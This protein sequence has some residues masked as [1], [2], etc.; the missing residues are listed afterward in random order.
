MRKLL[1]LC[2]VILS[3]Q[4]TA[5]ET[6]Y[7]K[8]V[9]ILNE[10]WFGHDNSSIS[11]FDEANE[12]YYGVFKKEN[13]PQNGQQ[14]K[15]L[16]CTAQHGIIYGNKMII[17]AKQDKEASSMADGGRVT[18]AEYPSL[19]CIKQ[20]AMLEKNPL[21]GKSMADGRAC[22]G[23]NDSTVYLGSSNGIFV[24]NL[25]TLEIEKK[26]E[27]TDN[28]LITGDE[29]NANGTGPLYRNQIGIMIRGTDYVFA[30]YQDKGVLVIDPVT[31]SIIRT[32]P[33]CYS[34]MVMDVKGNI[35][36]G[37]NIN[38]N[39]NYLEYPYGKSGEE[40]WGF[41]LLKINQHTL[42]TSAIRLSNDKSKMVTQSWYAWTPGVLQADSRY[43][44]LYW[45]DPL[46]W[47]HGQQCKK[48]YKLDIATQQLSQHFDATTVQGGSSNTLYTGTGFGVNPLNNQIYAFIQSGAIYE[49]NFLLSRL[50]SNG[51]EIITKRLVS[52]WWYPSMLI[53]ADRYAPELKGE[54]P[55]TI[56]INPDNPL[57][58]LY[59]GDK[60]TDKDNLDAAIVKSAVVSNP[61]IV[62]AWVKADTLYAEANTGEP[63]VASLSLKFNSNGKTISHGINVE[64]V[65]PAIVSGVSLVQSQI[66]LVKGDSVQLNATIEPANALN[67]AV[68]WTTDNT[69][70]ATVTTNGWVKG[71]SNGKTTVTVTTAQ[72][73]YTST[74]E[75]TVIEPIQQVIISHYTKELEINKPFTIIATPMPLEADNRALT[76]SSSN[77]DV[78]KVEPVT[79]APGNKFE[80]AIV[81]A[82]KPGEAK[83]YAASSFMPQV[84]DSCIVLIGQPVVPV[85]SIDIAGNATLYTGK[86]HQL[87]A[88][89]LPS[90]ATNPAIRWSSNNTNIA[91]VS[92]NGLVQGI[93]SGKAI[94]SATAK[95]GGLIATHEITVLESVTNLYLN[96]QA[97]MLNRGETAQLTAT[98]L[99]AN[100]HNKAIRWS[101]SNTEVATVSDD[102]LVTTIGEGS[103]LLVAT[104]ESDAN[105]ADT[106]KIIVA[107]AVESIMV[108]PEAKGLTS[109]DSIQ[110]TPIITPTDATNPLVSWYSSDSKVAVVSPLGMVKAISKGEATITAMV[111]GGKEAYCMITVTD[112]PQGNEPTLTEK[113]FILYPN[114]ASHSLYIKGLTIPTQV[115]VYNPLGVLVLNTTVEPNQ[116]INTSLLNNG[117][118]LVKVNGLT[119]K[120]IINQP[121]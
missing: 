8:G 70:I 57:F 36:V 97:K 26:I 58:K 96:A 84:K 90:N 119:L 64:V 23:V 65:N 24:L 15:E 78:L 102:G 37:Q 120:L 111:S 51:D 71:I 79:S 100:A 94:I 121:N 77:P 86:T 53:P 75:V 2:L 60:A 29:S 116:P 104:S 80:T 39:P 115:S 89:I 47:F 33:G 114:P 83:I 99:P 109:G 67:P 5:Q 91:T 72:R 41:R 54:F 87:S 27:D 48:I 81:T 34:T 20:I 92:P 43:E 112:T 31:H 56:L 113:A 74:C 118:Y 3:L 9:F 46:T 14:R 105:H 10:D 35:W 88:S 16:G 25:N 18:I 19:K 32:I 40:W 52:H 13:P 49:P 66:T 1:T 4:T 12:I 63:G 103:A 82:L 45:A 68:T 7:T 42:E 73:S 30:I 50:S 93:T 110:L 117:M 17:M 38:P 55:S 98:I 21:T 28:P 6:D 85:S 59:V 44:V 108:S 69:S 95:A 61:Y 22:V 62:K 76:W 106:C 11:F 107:V 101:S